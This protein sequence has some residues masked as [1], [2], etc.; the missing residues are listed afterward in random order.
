LKRSVIAKSRKMLASRL[1]APGPRR[2]L[3]PE[4][5]DAHRG[6][7]NEGVRIEI[8]SCPG[9]SAENRHFRFHWSAVCVRVGGVQDWSRQKLP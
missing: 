5:A 8:T 7:R 3:R 2:L 4:F 6:D 9:V 1:V